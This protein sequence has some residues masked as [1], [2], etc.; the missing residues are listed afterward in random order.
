M[1]TVIAVSLLFSS[2]I[3]WAQSEASLRAQQNV[4]AQSDRRLQQDVFERWALDPNPG[5]KAR[6]ARQA[7]EAAE[8]YSKARHF[9]DLWQKF[10]RELND[11]QTFDAKLALKISKAFHDMEHS[12][13]WP[14]GR[15]KE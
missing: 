6:N 13:G 11:K 3:L 9:V 4:D 10:A 1:K 7:A 8:F 12:D 14:V 2:Q 15:T 5:K